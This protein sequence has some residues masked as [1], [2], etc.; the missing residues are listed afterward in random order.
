M[1][2]EVKRFREVDGIKDRPRAR[3]EFVKLIRNG[4]R[5]KKYNQK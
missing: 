5:M 1:P 3:L 4:L 2:V